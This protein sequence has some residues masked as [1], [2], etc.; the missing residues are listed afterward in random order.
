MR[1]TAATSSGATRIAGSKVSDAAA[2]ATTE[3]IM[4]IAIDRNTITGTKIEV[5][6]DVRYAGQAFE[7]T[8]RTDPAPA[9]A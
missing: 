3:R 5:P 8:V 4:P 2:V 7:L 1:T 6:F 9:V